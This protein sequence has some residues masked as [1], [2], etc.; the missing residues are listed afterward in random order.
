M[1]ET[2]G[3]HMALERGILVG[4]EIVHISRRDAEGSRGL[5][6]REVGIGQ[7]SADVGLQ[8]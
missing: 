7:V 6:Q 2:L 3:K 1:G 4:K 8:G 5:R